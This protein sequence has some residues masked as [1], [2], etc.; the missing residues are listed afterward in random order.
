MSETA[1]GPLRV[2]LAVLDKQDLRRPP[3]PVA[4]ANE[5][6]PGKGAKRIASCIRQRHRSEPRRG[7]KRESIRPRTAHLS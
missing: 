3:D 7:W 1:V 2:R 4:L 6:G 5:P